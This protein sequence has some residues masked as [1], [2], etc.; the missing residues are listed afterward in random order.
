VLARKLGQT[1]DKQSDKPPIQC[2]ALWVG[3]ISIPI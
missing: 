3:E 2:R 1:L